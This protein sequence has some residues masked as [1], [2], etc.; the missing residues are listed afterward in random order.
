V[1]G[2]LRMLELTELAELLQPLAAVL[3]AR[4]Q[5][6]PTVGS[7]ELEAMA[8]AIASVEWFLEDYGRERRRAAPPG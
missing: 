8:D 1:E 3:E 5:P 6:L 2:A 4:E 7:R